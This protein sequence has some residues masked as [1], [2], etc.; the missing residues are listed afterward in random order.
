MVAGMTGLAD[1]TNPGQC[2]RLGSA[3]VNMQPTGR[4]DEISRRLASAYGTPDLGNVEDVFGELVYALLSTRTAPS[5]YQKAFAELRERFPRW[6]DLASASEHDVQSLL[7]P[8][9]LHNRKAQAILAIARRVFTEQGLADLEH[10]LAMSTEDAEAY[11]TSLPG[12]GLK[13]AKCVCLYALK[14]SVFPLDTHNLRVLRRLGVVQDSATLH[15]ATRFVEALIP[16][17]LRHDLHVNLVVH[18]RQMC[19]SRPTC[20]KC[21]LRDMCPQPTCE[22]EHL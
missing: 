3:M 1:P 16:S 22:E 14:R 13:V 12:V 17:S 11:L 10:L 4:I 2:P 6:S 9:G 15:Q 20:S 19:R 18:G 5:N 21:V 7:R 8:C